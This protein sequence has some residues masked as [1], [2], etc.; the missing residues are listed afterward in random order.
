MTSAEISSDHLAGPT[1]DSSMQMNLDNLNIKSPIYA[2][3]EARI[4]LRIE[5]RLAESTRLQQRTLSSEID[6]FQ[7]QRAD[8]LRTLTEQTESSNN[9][10]SELQRVGRQLG[11]MLNIMEKSNSEVLAQ[12]SELIIR[13]AGDSTETH[14]LLV[15]QVEEQQK[16]NEALKSFLD[17]TDTIKNQ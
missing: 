2:G 11:T 5:E 8:M 12:L 3:E 9:F 17:A 4:L 15:I 6:D 7:K 1:A 14:K 10:R 16:L 13:T